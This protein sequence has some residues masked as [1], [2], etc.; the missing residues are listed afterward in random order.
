MSGSKKWGFFTQFIKASFK[1]RMT[2]T[3]AAGSSQQWWM[4]AYRERKSVESKGDDTHK[5][6]IQ[7]YKKELCEPIFMRLIFH[8]PYR[9]ISFSSSF[10]VR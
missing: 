5:M 7:V 3:A 6:H 2:K 1:N 9:D 8:A 10:T 4:T